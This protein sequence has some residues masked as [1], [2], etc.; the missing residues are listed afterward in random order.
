M[1]ET[2][3]KMPQIQNPTLMTENYHD[4]NTHTLIVKDNAKGI[5]ADIQERIFDPY[6]STKKEKDGT[7]L[8]LYMSKT[9]IEEHCKGSIRVKNDHEGAVFTITIKG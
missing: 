6:F 1:I 3:S 8:G 5:S 4:N 7:G 9:I 2:L